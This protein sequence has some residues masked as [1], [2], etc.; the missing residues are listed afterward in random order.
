MQI[1]QSGSTSN[2]YAEA[3]THTLNWMQYQPGMLKGGP[4]QLVPPTGQPTAAV[5]ELGGQNTNPGGDTPPPTGSQ[6]PPTG[7]TTPPP[8]GTTTPP[9]VPGGTPPPTTP[10]GGAPNNAQDTQWWKDQAAA[11]AKIP[12]FEWLG[13]NNAP[14]AAYAAEQQRNGTMGKGPTFEEWAIDNWDGVASMAGMTAQQKAQYG[15]AVAMKSYQTGATRLQNELATKDPNINQHGGVAW[16]TPDKVRAWKEYNRFLAS[17]QGKPGAVAPQDFFTWAG[18][19]EGKKLGNGPAPAGPAPPPDTG[20]PHTRYYIPNGGTPAPTAPGGA[21]T[22]TQS[23]EDLI[24]S[25]RDQGQIGRDASLRQFRHEAGLSGLNDMGAYNPALGTLIQNSMRDENSAIYEIIN[26]KDEGE[27]NRALQ[28]YLGEIGASA[29]VQAAG[30]GAAGSAYAAD[31]NLEA[32]KYSDDIRKLLG[33]G[34]LDVDRENNWWN[35][36]NNQ[37]QTILD[38]L[39]LI[40]GASP[41]GILG[42]NPIPG[43]DGY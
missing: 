39:R 15:Y 24:R 25:L 37:Q 3:V 18:S 40:M 21:P 5:G 35:S 19:D 27:R 2:P 12:G 23:M 8:A 31:W 10:G 13:A 14:W 28:K 26:A 16:I 7:T 22:G 34:G 43:G 11:Y 32:S 9:T 17:Q 29:Q 6:P 30:A 33:L 1:P 41:D 42:G 20:N 36:Q 4:G 38:Y